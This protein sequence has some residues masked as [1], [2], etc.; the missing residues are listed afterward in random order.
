M[1][2]S[3]HWDNIYLPGEEGEELC[4]NLLIDQT[5][6]KKQIRYVVPVSMINKMTK[7]DLTPG[8]EDW[9]TLRLDLKVVLT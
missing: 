5:H 7:L 8:N 2:F 4:M 1:I 6:T 9:W 3:F